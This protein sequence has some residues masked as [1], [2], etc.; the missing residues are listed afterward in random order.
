M[1]IKNCDSLSLFC[2]GFDKLRIYFLIEIPCREGFEEALDLNEAINEL[3]SRLLVLIGEA[4][5]IKRNALINKPG[6][7]KPT[8]ERILKKLSIEPL[9][10]IEYQG[11]KKT[12]GYFLTDKGKV[13][14]GQIDLSN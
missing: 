6:C 7:S 12:G 3:E 14:V 1:K 13:F 5:N 4:P 2:H 9:D 8:L 10:F 11:S